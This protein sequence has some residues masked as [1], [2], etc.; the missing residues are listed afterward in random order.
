M[1]EGGKLTLTTGSRIISE[2]FVKERGYGT[3]GD[4][5]LLSVSDTGGGMSAGTMEK[6]FEPFFT[7]KETG[8][9]TGLGLSIVY[10]IIKQ[11]HGFIN[12][13][14]EIGKGS[15]FEIYLPLSKAAVEEDK[16]SVSF[17]PLGGS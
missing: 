13:S 14:S 2:A 17:T 4:Y 16:T 9:G 7:T 6:I 3:P 10:G 12:V 1:P 5:A 11:S 15:T 8:K